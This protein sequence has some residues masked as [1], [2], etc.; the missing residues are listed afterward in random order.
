MYHNVIQQGHESI[1]ICYLKYI[2][3]ILQRALIHDSFNNRTIASIDA[4]NV[5]IDPLILTL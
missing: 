4:G 2:T 1:I 5:P 3:V